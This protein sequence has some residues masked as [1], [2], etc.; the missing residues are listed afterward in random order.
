MCPRVRLLDRAA[1]VTIHCSGRENHKGKSS[2]INGWRGTLSNEHHINLRVDSGLG[3]LQAD[4]GSQTFGAPDPFFI[5]AT[6]FRRL[7]VLAD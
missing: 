6:K 2:A 3:P 5:G 4:I 1:V 7:A